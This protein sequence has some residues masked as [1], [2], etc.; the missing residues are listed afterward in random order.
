MQCK[1]KIKSEIYNKKV[2]KKTVILEFLYI[3][4]WYVSRN[5]SGKILN[6]PESMQRKI[7]MSIPPL[8]ISIIYKFLQIKTQKPNQARKNS[9]ISSKSMT[10]F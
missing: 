8:L 5:Q 3:N 1:I 6:P 2:K 10:F 9:F 7:E 4:I